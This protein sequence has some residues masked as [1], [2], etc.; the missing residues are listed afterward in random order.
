MSDISESCPRDRH[1]VV[2]IDDDPAVRGLLQDCLQVH[3][4]AVRAAAD[5]VHGLALVD[6]QRPV[7]VVLDVM[8]PQLD[9]HSVLRLLRERHGFSLPVIMLTAASDDDQ[10]WQAWAGGVDCFMAKPFDMDTLLRRIHALSPPADDDAAE[11]S[12]DPGC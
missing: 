1:D 7:C 9:G 2:I 6:E 8:M 5:G 4:F 3:G 11:V 10:A 12:A